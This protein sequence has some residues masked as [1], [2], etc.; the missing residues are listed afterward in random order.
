MKKLLAPLVA[1]ALL[2]GCTVLAA[3]AGKGNGGQGKGNQ[4]VT[5]AETVPVETVPE[6]TWPPTTTIPFD[7]GTPITGYLILGDMNPHWG[8]IFTATYAYEGTLS[9]RGTIFVRV[10]CVQGGRVV[11]Q[12]SDVGDY[13]G[14]NFLLSQQ[15]GLAA[16]GV[17]ID[18]ASPGSCTVELTYRILNDKDHTY[19][20]LDSASFTVLP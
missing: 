19:Q 16:V 15:D 9:N 6:E 5:V 1:L 2:S 7:P 10:V 8:D 13:A 20:I 17:L 12:G 11:W 18:T 4:P 14:G 3:R